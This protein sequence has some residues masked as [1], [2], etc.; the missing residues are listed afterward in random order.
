MSKPEWTKNGTVEVCVGT[1]G[2]TGVM[3]GGFVQVRGALGAPL[4]NLFDD[5][6]SAKAQ[7]ERKHCQPQKPRHIR[8]DYADGSVVVDSVEQDEQGRPLRVAFIPDINGEP[9]F[10]VRF[11]LRV[12]IAESADA[13]VARAVRY[14]ETGE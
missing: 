9:L 10:Q 12:E 2:V 6:Q 3:G 11:L 7:F 5:V 8:T 14:V 4:E 13:I 1:D